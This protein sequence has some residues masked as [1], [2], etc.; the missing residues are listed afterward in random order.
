MMNDAELLRRYAKDRTEDAFAELVRRHLSLVY[1]AALRRVGGDAPLA[2]EVA[3]SVFTALAREAAALTSHPSLDGWLYTTTRNVAVQAQRAERRRRAREQ[4][5]HTMQNDSVDPY[6]EA[7]WEQLRPVI[8]EAMDELSARDREA[9]LLR[10]FSGRSFAEVGEKLAI[11]ENTA[12]MRAERALDKLRALLVRRGI[13]STG[14]A[15]TVALANQVALAAPTGLATTVTGAALAGA[16][17]A[18]GGAV[19]VQ[20]L[21]HL[22][23]TTKVTIGMACA[24][25]ILGVGSAVYEA[26]AAR[27]TRAALATVSDELHKLQARAKTAE[28]RVQAAESRAQTAEQDCDN[29][30]KMVAVLRAS[31]ATETK[32]PI[33]HDLV[34]ARYK[35]A[36]ELAR[37]GDAAAALKEFLWCLD[38]GMVQVTSY[39]GVR[40]SFLLN[41]IA[42]LGK[43]D[44]DA[45]AALRER[46]DVAEKRALASGND[47]D[48]SADFSAIN[49]ALQE[50]GRSLE[51][52]D[53]LAPDD[54]RR[55]TL[56]MNV[57]ELLVGAQRYSDAAQAKSFAQMSS[58]F[59][60]S[61]QERPLPANIS[62][63][64]AIRQAQRGYLVTSTA[65]NIEVLAGAGDLVHARTLVDKLL[66]YDGSDQTRAI[67]QQRAVRAGHPELMT[68]P[69]DK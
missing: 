64:A 4:E 63:P 37:N 60:M 48:A 69:P 49:H 68:P 27:H 46:R 14:A 29:L 15:L 3:Q 23:S 17:A 19:A 9:I 33:T 30:L 61:A 7:E 39:T 11:S 36:Q 56:G 34:E 2:E 51:F 52:Y 32:V 5:A 20:S 25:A 6:P 47:F 66:A 53:R 59:D 35:R 28:T 22:M 38:E 40:R 55:H 65:S 10:Y 50:D 12:R 62:N 54:P 26:N 13:T 1:F 57:Y 24:I 16:S 58:Q 67:L 18:G 42:A 41:S 21:F 45:L 31:K 8:D 43:S 44:P